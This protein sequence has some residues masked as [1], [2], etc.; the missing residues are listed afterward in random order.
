[1]P[2]LP[3]A[4]LGIAITRPLEQAQTLAERVRAC[5]GHPILFPLLAIE[6]L[7]DY[8]ACDAAIARLPQCDWAVFISSN[9]VEHGMARV[10]R[11]FPTLP[12]GP[13][14][15]AV[16]PA[17][18]GCLRQAGV[19]QVLTPA[20]GFDSEAL[21]ALPELQQV[22]GRRILIFRGQGGREL[23]A[24]TL[25]QRGAEVLLAECYRRR[26]PQA[27]AGDLPRLWHNRQLHAI[28]VSSSEALRNLLALGEGSNWLHA[29]L[30]CVNHPRIAALAQRHGLMVATASAP[31]D[32]ALLQCLI[33]NC[34][35]HPR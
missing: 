12:D 11:Q 3:L 28:V 7:D 25:R 9:A 30:L 18:A 32:E 22:Q 23:L 2:E 17:S 27:D 5:G 15:A 33:E 13:R 29:T 35:G 20:S 4:G 1:M 34:P 6:A 21:L 31:N 14:Y 8:G 26:N 10:R 16:G 24:E 19:P